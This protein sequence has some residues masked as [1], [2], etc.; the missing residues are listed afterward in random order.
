MPRLRTSCRKLADLFD[1]LGRQAFGGFVDH[2]QVRVAHQRAAQGQHLLLAA[3]EHAAGRVVAFL[4]AREQRVHVVDAP[5]P[6]GARVLDAQH[7][8]LAHRQV[9]KDVAVFGTRPMPRRAIS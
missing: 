9:G 8:V 3:G 5:A 6:D 4:E 2:D 1:D 7:Q